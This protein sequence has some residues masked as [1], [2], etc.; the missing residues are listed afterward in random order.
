MDLRKEFLRDIRNNK[1]EVDGSGVLL[2]RHK[3]RIGGVFTHALKR[4]GEII[5]IAEDHNLMVSE[6]LNHA[7][8]VAYN[9][10]VQIASW[11]IGLFEGNYTPVA[12]DTAATFA[13]AATEST[14]YTQATRP[15]WSVAAP[16]SQQITNSASKAQFTMNATKTI[17]GAFIISNSTKGG[18]SGTLTAAS[19]FASA[20]NVIL[21]DEL[22]ITYTLSAADA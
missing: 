20:R 12:G 4:D 18:T 8:D 7:L 21:D 5:D 19:R 2:P 17:Y 3:I 16:A 10:G 11:Y 6:G 22:L 9:G 1:Y 15:L 14:A 13:T